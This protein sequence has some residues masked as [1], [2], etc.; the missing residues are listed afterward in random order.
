MRRRRRR[1]RRAPS[2]RSLPKKRAKLSPTLYS[3]SSIHLLL[4]ELGAARDRVHRLGEPPDV[5]GVDAR[6]AVGARVCVCVERGV[7]RQARPSNQRRPPSRHRSTPPRQP[8]NTP[9]RVCEAASVFSLSPLPPLSPLP[10]A[11]V[12]RQVDRVLRRQRIAHLGSHP[13]VRKHAFFV[14]LFVVVG[15]CCVCVVGFFV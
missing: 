13:R 3:L 2:A 12:A 10:D 5:A 6:H 1:R 9:P 11:A 15:G 8:H 7:V 4:G 14:F